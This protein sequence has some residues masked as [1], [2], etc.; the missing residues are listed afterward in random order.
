MK[1]E[2]Q[3]ELDGLQGSTD[4]QRNA[5]VSAKV[6][7]PAPLARVCMLCLQ[8][9]RPQAALAR[10]E[11]SSDLA[12]TLNSVPSRPLALHSNDLYILTAE[13]LLVW[14]AFTFDIYMLD[15]QGT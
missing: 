6:L 15:R 13:D 3:A 11:L 7:E 14:F 9:D 8:I 1:D 5:E 2:L 10:E 4:K 12:A